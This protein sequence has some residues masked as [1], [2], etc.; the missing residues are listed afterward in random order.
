[1]FE[2][3]VVSLRSCDL[4]ALALK[5]TVGPAL[6]IVAGLGGAA[7]WAGPDVFDL[8][9][10][11]ALWVLAVCAAAAYIGRR[12]LDTSERD[13]AALAITARM[14]ADGRINVEI[15]G[16]DR[17]DCVGDLARA[18]AFLRHRL[19]KESAAATAAVVEAPAK[20]ATA[21]SNV[22][23]SRTALGAML[24]D[25]GAVNS[26]VRE[27]ARVLGEQVKR[28][29]GDA[30]AAREASN[31]GAIAVSSLAAAV[32]QIAGAVRS[33]SAQ[34]SES[35][36]L[37]RK[38][39]NAGATAIDHVSQLSQ[40]V[41][42]IGRVVTSIRAIAEQTNLLALNATI[43]ASRAGEAGR[44]FAVV[45]AEVKALATETARAT[46]EITSLVS[47]IQDVT[48]A[49]SA[50]TRGIGQQ[51]EAVDEASRVIAAA[52]SEQEISTNEIARNSTNAARH[53]LTAHEH[54][55][56]IEAAIIA[57]GAAVTSLEGATQRFNET[58]GRI[59]AEI[60]GLIDTVGLPEPVA[61]AA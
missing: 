55:T 56:A 40:A 41:Q 51:L 1:V 44:G 25:A 30:H 19:H 32:D 38:A 5:L 15:G 20:P 49:A 60:D 23:A 47:R 16:Q 31:Q 13:M 4:L 26:S 9:G 53:S 2:Q 43:E 22:L 21:V 17:T 57:A 10:A 35:T 24:V 8:V 52:V 18:L 29:I 27:T 33:I 28:A 42:R 61:R 6:L 48:T 46:A 54:F 36:D 7:L 45:A 37:V 3:P 14:L 12:I 39:S 11:I 50:A 59:Q 34:A 58:T